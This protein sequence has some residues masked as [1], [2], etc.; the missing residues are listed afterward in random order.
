MRKVIIAGIISTV[1]GGLILSVI[2]PP[3]RDVLFKTPTWAWAGV[4]WVWDLL[5]SHYSLPGWLLL[6]VGLYVLRCLIGSLRRG[7]E[8]LHAQ[9]EPAY[10]GYTE[11]MLDGVKWRWSWNNNA[12]SN[13]WCFCSR[14]D[15]QLVYDTDFGVTS[16]ICE[17]CP[18]DG[19]DRQYRSRGRVVAAIDG[20]KDYAVDAAEREILRRIRTNQYTLPEN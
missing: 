5:I 12:I 13:L 14:C 6:I 17:R 20:D 9:D 11:D 2:L 10:L 15:A 19:I 4:V 18:P 8:V 7:Y 1:A 16:L 3:L